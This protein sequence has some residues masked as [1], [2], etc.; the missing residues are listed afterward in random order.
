MKNGQVQS[1]NDDLFEEADLFVGASVDE[2]D[3]KQAELREK[4]GFDEYLTWEFNPDTSILKLKFEGMPDVEARCGFFATYCAAD[5]TLEWC[6]NNPG[7]PKAMIEASHVVREFGEKFELKY[8]TQGMIPIP[9]GIS[10]SY[11]C[12]LALKA[13][14]AMGVFRGSEGEVHP[15]FV[16]FEVRRNG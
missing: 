14:E 5:L 12:S 2:F 8:L 4:W 7:Y 9:T 6:W 13:N 11:V 10:L 15:L 1:L 3:L 16:V